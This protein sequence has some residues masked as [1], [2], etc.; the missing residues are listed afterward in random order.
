MGVT[1]AGIAGGATDPNAANNQ[2]QQQNTIV[3]QS[4]LSI[5]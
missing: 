4:L 2:Q 5:N 1:G 3:N